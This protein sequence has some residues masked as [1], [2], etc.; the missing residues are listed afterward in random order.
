MRIFTSKFCCSTVR[1]FVGSLFPGYFPSVASQPM[2]WVWIA[3]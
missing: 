1:M 3:W 2:V